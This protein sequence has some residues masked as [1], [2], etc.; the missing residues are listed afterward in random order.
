MRLT[1]ML[2]DGASGGIRLF[3]LIESDPGGFPF[4][5][6]SAFFTFPSGIHSIVASSVHS[7]L[8]CS[9]QLTTPARTVSPFFRFKILAAC[10]V[11]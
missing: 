1:R 8:I 6:T 3:N 5:R 4:F 11:R 7:P 9:S 2:S 10:T